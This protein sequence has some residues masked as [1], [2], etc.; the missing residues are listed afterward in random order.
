MAQKRNKTAEVAKNSSET[1][2]TTKN[3][4]IAQTVDTVFIG[5]SE[6]AK[7]LYTLIEKGGTLNYDGMK[8]KF[9]HPDRLFEGQKLDRFWVDYDGSS[10]AFYLKDFVETDDNYSVLWLDKIAE[11]IVRCRFETPVCE[12]DFDDFVR[13]LKDLHS[14]VTVDYD[15][16]GYPIIKINY[17]NFSIRVVKGDF[18]WETDGITFE[19]RAECLEDK[20]WADIQRTVADFSKWLTRESVDIEKYFETK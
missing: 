7:E 14:D 17:D 9:H 4:S 20:D 8:I 11:M 16:F 18:W 3:T 2:Q 15:R 12:L 19:R 13:L 1:A 10:N 5:K 6:L